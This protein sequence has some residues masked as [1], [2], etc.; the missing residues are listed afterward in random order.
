[1]SGHAQCRCGAPITDGAHLCAA[2]VS[3][4]RDRLDK[5]ADRWPD[6]IDALTSREPAGEKGGQQKNGALHVGTPLNE[7]VSRAMAKCREVLWFIVQVIRDDLDDIGRKFSPPLWPDEGEMARWVLQWQ[8]P[9]ITAITARETAE[10]IADD[11]AAA[12]DATYHALNP[13]RW[14]KA[15]PCTEHGTSDMGERVPCTGTLWARVDTGCMPD[16]ECDADPMHRIG[17]VVWARLGWKRRLAEPL[18]PAGLRALDA[19]LRGA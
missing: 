10:E 2:C 15:I 8:V 13:Q 14:I 5:I 4:V 19:R 3:A 11:L 16:L 6:L 7:A 12:E 17:P 18:D 1:M 9:H